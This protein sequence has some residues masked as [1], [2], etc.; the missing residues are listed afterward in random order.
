NGAGSALV[1]STF[2]G[3]AVSD[4]AYGLAVDSSGNAFVTGETDSSTYPTTLGAFD[5]TYNGVVD[6]FVTKLNAAGSSLVY[7]TFIGGN[8]DDG[9]YGIAADSTGN[10]FV[11]GYTSGGSTAFPT[12]AGAFDTTHNGSSDAFVTKL[13]PAG[14]L[15]VYSTF[16]GGSST[17]DGRAITVDASGNAILTGGTS[18]AD[19]PTTAGAFD[20]T[21][22][23]GF[24]VF[25]TKVNTAG[26][27][28]DH[29]TFLGGSSLDVGLGLAVDSSGNAFVT[30]ETDSS[31][32][33]TTAGAFDT[34]QNGSGDGFATKL[35]LP[36][37]PAGIE[38]DV[39]SRPNGDGSLL[40]N[41]LVQI[42]R[43]VSG[44]DTA[45]TSP[46]E[47]Q[48]ADS[49]PRATLG[50]GLLNATDIV[51]ARRYVSGLDPLTNAG[52][53]TVAADPSIAA[54]FG[55]GLFGAKV[56][57]SGE[58]R[59]TGRKSGT[60][61]VEL[62]SHREVAAVS[63]RVKYDLAKFGKPT[64]SLGDLPEGSVL[65]LNDTV[66]GELTIVIDS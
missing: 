35:D 51:Q 9:G 56:G 50:D 52:G 24:D 11:T 58:L 30:G 61:L 28:L 20:T 62:E 43:F 32:Y 38:A 49:A 25:V 42:R 34:T 33:P 4:D 63:F 60:V 65:T 1:Y 17:E 3:G 6:A 64:V 44:L 27:S 36:T 29:S 13:N 2:I 18:S 39:A 53:P 57:E 7:S 66:E 46:N 37:P 15:L 47:F 8:S 40:S 19:Y 12:T 16:V 45:A 23:G 10:A 48:R 31:A 14:S 21:H 5:T 59:L 41:D 55:G 22:N 54:V 26:T